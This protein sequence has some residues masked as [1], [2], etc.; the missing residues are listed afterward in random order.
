MLRERSYLQRTDLLK[1][2][3]FRL[4]VMIVVAFD[5]ELPIGCWTNLHAGGTVPRASHETQLKVMDNEDEDAFEI[6]MH[7]PYLTEDL[8]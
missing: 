2:C 5:F 6:R 1:D 8:W 3:C 7:R 4:P